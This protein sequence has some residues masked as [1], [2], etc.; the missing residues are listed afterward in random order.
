MGGAVAALAEG[1]LRWEGCYTHFHSSDEP[2]LAPTF[3]QWAR[4]EAALARLPAPA[5]GERR[6]VHAA[7]SGAALR[8]GGF[9]CDLARPGISL[10]GG[11]AGSAVV[12]AVVATVRARLVLVREVEAGSTAGY[13]ATY[14]AR[15]RERWGTVAIG[16]GDGIPRALA[17]G[18]GDVLLHGRRVP[19]IGRVSMDVLTVNLS[20]VPEAAIGDVAT[21]IGA[22]GGAEI[23]LD[24]VAARSGTI[25]YEILTGLTQ[26]LPR[27]YR[28]A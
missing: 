25:A 6:V 26:R 17:T 7:N 11:R 14:T 5:A 28:N 15:H 4:F 19:I 23:L 21:L 20:A 12:P 22:D 3:R 18:G 27:V 24:E 10:Y 1:A 8:C 9:A 2:D 13:G 16:Y